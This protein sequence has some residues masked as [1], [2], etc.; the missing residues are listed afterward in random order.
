MPIFALGRS[1][2]AVITHILANICTEIK[3]V[4]LLS[5]AGVKMYDYAVRQL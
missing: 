5:A 1:I 4:V 2:C 3:V